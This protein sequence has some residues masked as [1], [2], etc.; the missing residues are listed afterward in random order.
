ME[1]TGMDLKPRRCFLQDLQSIFRCA[2]SV[3][4]FTNRN[5][6]AK[7]KCDD[8]ISFRC[9]T[10]QMTITASSA[11]EPAVAAHSQGAIASAELPTLFERFSSAL[12]FL[13]PLSEG[14]FRFYRVPVL[15]LKILQN[16]FGFCRH[17]QTMGVG[18]SILVS[19]S[20]PRCFFI[21]SHTNS[22]Q[23]QRRH[24]N[25]ISRILRF[26]SFPGDVTNADSNVGETASMVFE[27]VGTSRGFDASC[28]T[29]S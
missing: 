23:R 5:S 20:T 7:Q 21:F 1:N 24:R 16:I 26:C 14:L 3:D 29:P 18:I 27:L 28:S 4:G 12:M 2:L 10:N 9:R 19:S 25:C 22:H 15:L 13:L 17:L 11:E 8:S 6:I